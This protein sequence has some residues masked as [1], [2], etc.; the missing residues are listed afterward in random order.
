MTKLCCIFNTPSIYREAIYKQIDAA[1]DCDW[2]FENTD[3][4]QEVFDTRQLR[5]VCYQ[6]S[7]MLGPI[8]WVHGLI[9]LLWNDRYDQYLLMGH[10]RNLSSFLFLVLKRIVSRRKKAYLWT[11]GY[12]GKE[13]WIERQWKKLLLG[14]ADGIFLYGRYA[15]E[16]MVKGGYDATKLHVIHNSLDY[17]E[18]LSIR[19]QIHS[20]NLYQEHFGND[21]PVVVFI[22]R[23]RSGKRLD[24]LIKSV[25]AQ[26]KHG[27]I[28]NLTLVGDGPDAAQLKAMVEELGIVEKVWFYGENFDQR[29]NAELIYNA[30]V[31]VAPGNVGLTA[32]H[33]LMFGCPVITHNDFPYQMP[34]FEAIREGKTGWYYQHGDQASLDETLCRGLEISSAER[35]AMRE[36]CYVEID[37]EWNPAW[38]MEVIKSVIQ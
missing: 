3:N 24:M 20:T 32:M 23:L 35:E 37:T 21:A 17:D 38:Q 4:E 26:N 28:C 13:S 5:Q 16:L 18:Q 6:R 33:A 2:Y 34:E 29:K 36:A 15:R 19:K 25:A 31:C 9:G 14:S 10:S 7:R 12:Y 30:W 11:H 27:Q 1:Y 8:Y 22:G